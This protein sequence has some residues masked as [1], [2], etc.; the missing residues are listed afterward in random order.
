MKGTIDLTTRRQILMLACAAVVVGASPLIG[1]AEEPQAQPR[2]P[3]VIVIAADDLGYGDICGYSCKGLQTPNIDSLGRNGIRFTDGHVTAPVCSPSRAGFITGRYQ[4]RY[5]HEFNAGAAARCE[6]EGLGLPTTETTLAQ[7]MKA[8]GYATGLVGKSHLGSQPQ[9]HPQKRGFDEFFGFLHGANL[10]MEPLDAPG[11]HFIDISNENLGTKRAE[12]N[13]IL[14][15]TEPV[16]EEEYLTDAFTREAVAF[17]ERHRAEPFFLYLAYNAPHTPLQV[18]DFYYQRFPHIADEKHRIYA[19]MVSALDDGVGR[20]LETLKKLELWND[21]LIF[22]FSDNGCA[23]YTEAC[24]NDPLLGGKLALFE[25]GQRVPFFA[26]YPA[27]IPA[28]ATYDRAVSTI[29]IYPT[30]VTLAGG[31]VPQDRDGVNLMP[32]LTGKMEGDPHQALF[33]RNGTNS[34][35][36]SGD[37]K[38]VNLGEGTHVLLYNVREDIGETTDLASQHPARVKELSYLLAGWQAQLVE[39]LWTSRMVIPIEIAGIK[40]DLF[41]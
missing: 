35:V 3:N 38:L 16:Q 10:Y 40:F 28:G 31:E 15:G 41:V 23:T 5:G 20:L 26:Q 7:A 13:P 24:Y 30:A 1:A 9:F 18:T 8:A 6:R 27:R 22:F 19:A 25:G 12:I 21:T 39:P 11:V 14:R 17:I 2:R 36:R 32:F 29:D 33:W 34:A 37:W 4:Q